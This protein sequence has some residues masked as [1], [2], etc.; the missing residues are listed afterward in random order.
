ML[1]IGQ[2]KSVA[3]AS[4]Y[5]E[6]DDYYHK[7]DGLAPSAWFGAAADHLG[8][9]GPDNPTAPSGTAPGDSGES[10]QGAPAVHRDTFRHAL[11]G[12]LPD[13]TRMGTVRDGELVHRAGWDLTFSAPKSVSIMATVGGDRRLVEAHDQAVRATLEH[14]EKTYATT[15]Q[16]GADGEIQ[17]VKTGA[18]AVAQFR[19]ETNRNLEPQLH[20]HNVMLN[21]TVG[22]DGRARSL[23]PRA[24]YADQKALG[25]MYRA[26]LATLATRLGYEV[27]RDRKDPTVFRL[28]EVP[29]ELEKAFSSRA[30][31]V[32]RGLTARGLDRTTATPRQAEHAAKDTRAKKQKVERQQLLDSWQQTAGAGLDALRT[33]RAQ[34]EARAAELG[35][36]AADREASAASLAVETAIRMLAE[37]QAV[38][39]DKR[40]AE[41]AQRLALGG[42]DPGRIRKA[43]LE[44]E[45]DGR[46]L[47]RLAIGP[48]PKT[49]GMKTER[50]WTTPA[51]LATEKAMIAT[52]EAGRYR[53]TALLGQG[54]AARYVR[55]AET[56]AGQLG[57]TWTTDQRAAA[58]GLLTTRDRVVGLQGFAGTAKTTTVL[59]TYAAAARARGLEVVAMAPTNDAAAV[60][61][62][63]V[64]AQGKTVQRHLFDLERTPPPAPRLVARVVEWFGGPEA[65]PPA[66]RQVWMV[67][68]ASLLGA[69]KM[70]DL[71][72][73]AEQRGARV[74]LVGDE[75]Q[76]A[77]VEA[78][79]AFGQLQKGGAL[80]TF[81]L[82]TIVRQRTEEGR[83]AVY[84]ALRQNVPAALAALQRGGGRVIVA[85]TPEARSEAIAKA[86]LARTPEERQRTIVIEPSREG[87]DATN[88][89]I[90]NG[91]IAEGRIQG[92]ELKVEALQPRGFTLAERG[93]ARSYSQGDVI[94][95][96]KDHGGTRGAPDFARDSYHTVVAADPLR[97]T[98]TLRG[99]DGQL[100]EL[101]PSRL[102]GTFAAEVHEPADRSLRAGDAIRWIRKD[103][104]RGLGNGATATVRAVDTTRGTA[105]VVTREGRQITLDL[106]Q[107]GDRHWDH[108]WVKTAYTAQ[109]STQ[110][111]V[112]F[113]A[114]SWRINLVDMRSFYVMV[115]RMRDEAIVV[116]DSRDRLAEG[117]RLRTGEK[118]AA[119]EALPW[120]GFVAQLDRSASK[121]ADIFADDEGG[122]GTGANG[123]RA[124]AGNGGGGSPE[125]QRGLDE[126]PHMGL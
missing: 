32:E 57:F 69:E 37:R 71:L 62:K 8:L 27:E 110:D 73:A 60:L 117:I 94:R 14:I 125:R 108:G 36:Q 111:S 81:R 86:W 119:L 88:Q 105:A 90:R 80:R 42:A 9:T 6:R 126:G 3:A 55:D 1:S 31:D 43:I 101:D 59:A 28:K 22:D 78:G 84:A 116:T 115:S 65:K 39:A 70:R 47:P 96:N 17:E 45:R 2:V 24:I 63:A 77:S 5:F 118:Q 85:A 103:T 100:R 50:G 106:S 112:I 21:M 49:R 20:T 87:R 89:E 64:G 72:Q 30:R 40:L 15:R 109:G 13:G 97:G 35:P 61:G 25:A 120:E 56:A 91:L 38:F 75:K 123:L 67:D 19:H 95:F 11:A 66:M 29:Q 44:A 58:I 114:E 34:A 82:E 83:E 99:R 48:D 124:S 102:I 121:A 79:R 51:A 68:E 46:L 52:V 4:Q 33:A 53:V 104:A 16:R 122:G 26:H 23:E 74:L 113:H 98:L 12:V 41:E 18:L 7:G 76:I 92:P 54:A 93:M 10:P 107:P